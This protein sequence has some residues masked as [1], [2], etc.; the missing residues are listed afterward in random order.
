MSF[1][2]FAS[3]LPDFNYE[4]D[5]CADE[6][7][8]EATAV[9]NAV[10]QLQPSAQGV[11]EAVYDYVSPSA[12]GT[13]REEAQRGGVTIHGIGLARDVDA[14]ALGGR[15]HAGGWIAVSAYQT[16]IASRLSIIP[17]GTAEP[18]S[19]RRYTF[20]AGA[21]HGYL[22]TQRVMPILEERGL[23]NY[24]VLRQMRCAVQRYRNSMGS[25]PML[26]IVLRH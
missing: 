1:S 24:G 5:N 17:I 8:F 14:L 13:A 9:I 19:C 20:S 22:F 15:A 25:I 6:D 10:R 11:A 4:R 2:I 21:E 26:Q 23:N 18:G 16:V 7:V 12:A 3:G